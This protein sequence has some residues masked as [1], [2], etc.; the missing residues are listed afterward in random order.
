MF[1]ARSSQPI[2]DSPIS[3][4]SSGAGAEADRRAASG[5]ECRKLRHFHPVAA[6]TAM[7][8]CGAL[9]TAKRVSSSSK[10]SQRHGAAMSGSHQRLRGGKVRAPAVAR[11]RR[12]SI[13]PRPCSARRARPRC[14]R[15]APLRGEPAGGSGPEAVQPV[16]AEAPA[17]VAE[18][19]P[20]PVADAV[21]AD[22]AYAPTEAVSDAVP[23]A[24]TEVAAPK[25]PTEPAPSAPEPASRRW[26]ARGDWVPGGSSGPPA[27]GAATDTV[28]SR[29]PRWSAQRSRR[30]R[31]SQRRFPE[32]RPHRAGDQ[33][34]AE[35]P[36]AATARRR[37]A[38]QDG[39]TG[40]RAGRPCGR[41]GD[42]A[43]RSRR[44]HEDR[45]GQSPRPI[46]AGWPVA[47]P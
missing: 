6:I 32:R 11:A 15:S 2:S 43:D 35:R 9:G 10:P 1:A 24:T 20:T 7:G 41:E 14:R 25:A 13:A 46:A 23:A 31:P 30:A 18:A 40:G 29:W 26:A 5:R 17:A 47:G 4:S 27:L 19:V 21:P 37:G 36:P 16:V 42:R 44:G 8:R 22:V 33:P 12:G 3:S 38:G 34:A 45:P 28:S 39:R